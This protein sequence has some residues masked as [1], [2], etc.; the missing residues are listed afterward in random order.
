MTPRTR[1]AVAAAL[2]AGHPTDAAADSSASCISWAAWS[3]T[4]T[5]GL[6]RGRSHQ[7]DPL[8]F[9]LDGDPSTCWVFAG[10]S[11]DPSY[12][13]PHALDIGPA[14]DELPVD[15]LRIMNGDNRSEEHYRRRSRVVRLGVWSGGQQVADV[16][17]PQEL[18]W[19]AVALPAGTAADLHL[20][21]L[22]IRQGKDAAIC[23]A[24]LELL[25]EGAPVPWDLPRCVIAS[26]GG[27][28]VSDTSYL[29]TRDG[30]RL[31]ADDAG[32]FGGGAAWS[33][34]GRHVASVARG[35]EKDEAWIAD[36]REG[37]IVRRQSLAPLPP[38]VPYLVQWKGTSVTVRPDP[39][40]AAPGQGES[41]TLELPR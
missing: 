35:T 7:G 25:R 37:S 2:L 19:H 27:E 1:I 13:T 11:P 24:G 33:A 22:E 9:L 6:W 41:V 16:A 23:L 34:D 5:E 31:A 4:T 39:S 20:E 12:G 8:T 21:L 32:F 18:G 40:E 26:D 15:G 36:A 28:A 29:M 10:A 38:E 30:A 3:V 17:L 14:G